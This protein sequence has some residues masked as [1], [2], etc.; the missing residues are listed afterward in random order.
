MAL[1]IET[2]GLNPWYGD[3]ITCTCAKTEN[4]DSIK[5]VDRDESKILDKFTGW[6][7][8]LKFYSNID[9]YYFLTKNGKQFDIPFILTRFTI[10]YGLAKEDYDDTLDFL[11]CE[12]FDLQEVTSK[13]VSLQ[14][15]AEL[16]NCTPKSGTGSNAIKLWENK[17]YDK[18]KKYCMQD[19]LTTIEVFEKWKQLRKNKLSGDVN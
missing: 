1:D 2:T 15:M 8:K 18:L 10:L 13:R 16:L 12:H 9:N 19:V 14:V 17:E 4:G 6:L 3:R 5:I 11:K 7:C